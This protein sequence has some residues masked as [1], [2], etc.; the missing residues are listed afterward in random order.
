MRRSF[1]IAGAV[2]FAL[3]VAILGNACSSDDSSGGSPDAQSSEASTSICDYY[4]GAGKPCS[5][6]SDQ[7]CFP[8]CSKGGSFCRAAPGGN[9]GVWVFV[10]DTSCNPEA[11]PDFDQFV[12]DDDSGTTTDDGSVTDAN[13]AGSSSGGDAS[14]GAVEADTLDASDSG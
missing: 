2:S 14:D 8:I 6:V 12:P 5:P 13:D 3:S 11:G 10:D 7:R 9:G 4:T 1:L